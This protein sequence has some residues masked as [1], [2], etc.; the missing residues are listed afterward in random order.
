L[1]PI[2]RG[3]FPQ[4]VSV[5]FNVGGVSNVIRVGGVSLCFM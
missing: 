1:V 5:S 2:D 4:F 3:V